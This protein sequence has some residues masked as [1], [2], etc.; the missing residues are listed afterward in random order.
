MRIS[1][2]NSVLVLVYI[3]TFFGSYITGQIAMIYAAFTK[4][5]VNKVKRAL[6]E[7]LK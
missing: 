6:R 2:R 3:N 1:C 7:Y 5:T 4:D